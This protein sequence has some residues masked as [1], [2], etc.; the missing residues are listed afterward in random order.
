MPT[1]PSL[2]L[3][4]ADPQLR[5]EI[6]SAAA[7]LDDPKPLLYHASDARQGVEIAR[8]RAVGLVLVEMEADVRVLAALA[9]ELAATGCEA[10][11][12][13]VFRPDGLAPEIPE[14]VLFVE[15]IRG[16][17]RDFL[18]RPVS[19]TELASLVERL[20]RP[21]ARSAAR[22]GAVLSFLSN[23]GGVGKSTLAVNVACGLAMRRPERVLLV[24]ASLQLGV[25]ASMLDLA[26]SAT[27]ADA[28]RE[29]QRLDETL[30]RQITVAHP[31][32][33]HLLAAPADALDAADVDDAVISR[34][35]SLA[36][37]AYDYV[38]VDTFPMLD[39]VNVAVLDLSDRAYLVFENVVPTLQGAV[40][41][42]RLMDSL[43]VAHER[44][45]LVLNRFTRLAGSLGPAD[46]AERLGRAVDFVLPFD[47]RVVVAANTGEPYVLRPPRFRA[48]TRRLRA[49]VDD[50]EAALAGAHRMPASQNGRG[51]PERAAHGVE[52]AREPL[53]GEG[54]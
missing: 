12:A 6:E 48:F 42:A 46:V 16:G 26:P 29:Q 2:L 45:R 30:I 17:V 13:A 24:D 53:G 35:I 39:G 33:L 38:V 5:E 3:I 4:T 21:R 19:S 47:S 20:A 31:S 8:S 22:L 49:L 23:K 1:T 7:A 36:R 41:L 51:A 37:R 32:G 50:A 44:Q 11:L 14:S 54:I 34:V 9:D 40:K 27:L 10:S 43:G 18:R 15:A 25:C 52:T 28:A